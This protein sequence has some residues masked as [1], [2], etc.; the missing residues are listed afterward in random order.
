MSEPGHGT[1]VIQAGQI[2]YTPAQ[3]YNGSDTFTYTVQDVGG[4]EDTATVIVGVTAVN[5]PP[6]ISAVENQTIS[7]DS[8]TGAL[9]FTVTDVDND[10]SALDVSAVSSDTDTIAQSGIVIISGGG[11]SRTVTVTPG[12]HQNTFDP[13]SSSHEPVTLTLT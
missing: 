6:V 12:E 3:D 9:S 8:S 10:D 1:A 5:D 7:E 2:V 13:D 4:L 11:S